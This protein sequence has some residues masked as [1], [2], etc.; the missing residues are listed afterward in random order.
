MVF[1]LPSWSLNRF[2]TFGRGVYSVVQ[3]EVLS[4]E[5]KSKLFLT[6]SSFLPL[7]HGIE[8]KGSGKLNGKPLERQNL[9]GK[10]AHAAVL[11]MISIE[12]SITG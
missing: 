9:Q 3:W 5:S 10:V 11:I 2:Q 8:V 4:G 12:N 7:T 6:I 1:A